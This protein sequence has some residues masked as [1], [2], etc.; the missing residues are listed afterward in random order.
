M[1]LDDLVEPSGLVDPAALGVATV[2]VILVVD[3]DLS[4]NGVVVNVLALGD[5]VGHALDLLQADA[6]VLERSKLKIVKM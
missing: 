5:A 1:H 3:R 4:A 2:G 6:V